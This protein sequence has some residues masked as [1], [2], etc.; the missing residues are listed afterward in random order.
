MADIEY[1]PIYE[2]S[3]LPL[4]ALWESVIVIHQKADYKDLS[5]SITVDPQYIRE[6]IQ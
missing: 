4:E 5:K 2:A 1:I 3:S 6:F